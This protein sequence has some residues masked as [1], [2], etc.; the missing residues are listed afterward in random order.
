M[1]Y[2]LVIERKEILM[3]ATMWMSLE[4]MELGERSQSLKT[5]W[6]HLLYVIFP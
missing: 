6:F 5:T 1:Q 3:D 4:N 2:Y